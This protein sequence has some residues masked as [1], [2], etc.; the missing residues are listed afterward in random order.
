MPGP[1]SA[2]HGDL[3]SCPR[4]AGPDHAV[5]RDSDG[6]RKQSG[7]GSE[8]ARAHCHRSAPGTS[9]HLGELDS[10]AIG[11]VSPTGGS[12]A[13]QRLIGKTWT[14]LAHQKPVRS[15][16]FTFKVRSKV[17]TTWHLRVTRAASKATRASVSSALTLRV[18]HTAYAVA[19]S[20]AAVTS[21]AA[22]VVTGEVAPKATGTVQLQRLTGTQWLTVAT[23]R[24][25]SASTFSASTSQPAG[26]VQLRVVKPYTTTLATG[27]STA[28]V[29]TVQPAPGAPTVTTVGLPPARV[30]QPFFAAL[31]AS[32]GVPGYAWSVSWPPAGLALSPA[33]VL[34]GTPLTQGP[35]TVNVTVTDAAGSTATASLP[36]TVAAPAGRLFS[37]GS[38]VIGQ[39][40]N[41]S[42]VEAHTLVPVAGQS[43]V[44]A[45]AAAYLS[46]FALDADGTVWAWGETTRASSATAPRSIRWP[47][48]RCSGSPA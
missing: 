33:G 19:A 46:A 44:V 4:L 28:V 26:S 1:Y 39:L 41:G 11:A 23:A 2:D 12:V 35:T 31:T 9:H 10:R 3:G 15:G 30:G 45:T 21:P 37:V 42:S 34:R 14:T 6:P 16:A 25:T 18:V 17:A 13:L 40:G 32:G 5:R 7:T 36:L 22:V 48:W 27:T 24:L 43:A 47:R 8:N 38:N 20:A 29:V